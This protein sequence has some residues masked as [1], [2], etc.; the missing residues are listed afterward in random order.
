MVSHDLNFISII[1]PAYNEEPIIRKN[2]LA[3]HDFL[4]GSGYQFELLVME[5]GSVDQTYQICEQFA[6]LHSNVK[7]YHSDERLGKGNAIK[8]GFNHSNG[9]IVIFIDSDLP[10]E[11][12]V[13][14]HLIQGLQDGY[15]MVIG[16][17]Y[18]PESVLNRNYYKTLKSRLYNWLI[19]IVF[20]T[21]ISDHQCGFKSLNKQELEDVMA[22]IEDNR[23]FFDTELLIKAKK[24]GLKV[25]EIPIT[26][27]DTVER[28]SNISI[29]EEIEIMYKYLQFTLNQ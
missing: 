4:S 28:K 24:K 20:S 16:S 27:T 8:R 2:L 12:S 14:P 11:L 26:W 1:L 15:S 23:F 3:V 29:W 6:E 9:G 13:L 22:N 19:D 10:V 17:R 21:G 5:D 18:H 25:K 7:V